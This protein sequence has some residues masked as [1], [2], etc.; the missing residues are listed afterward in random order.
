M[1]VKTSTLLWGSVFY[2][3]IWGNYNF[4]L[5]TSFHLDQQI[6]D[7]KKIKNGK[8]VVRNEYTFNN[9]SINPKKIIVNP[10]PILLVEGL[11]LFD[12]SDLLSLFDKKIF[13][14]SEIETMINR[15]IKSDHNIRVYDKDDVI[16][17]N[18]NHFIPAYKKYI[19]PHKDY[20]DIIV[21]NNKKDFEGAKTTLDYI[22]KQYA[23]YNK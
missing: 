5:P 6:D 12:N 20:S 19:I 3:K 18:E 8:K 16:Y 21:D 14:D 17:K 22:T 9:P 11:F 23:L 15:R 10:R 1:A 13:I 7:I 2:E 4:D